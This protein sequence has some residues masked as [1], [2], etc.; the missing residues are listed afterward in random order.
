MLYLH[1]NGEHLMMC[2]PQLQEVRTKLQIN[3]LAVEYPQYERN[4]LPGEKQPVVTV[5]QVLE[6]CWSVVEYI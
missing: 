1:G 5:E 4:Y 2:R 6:D 3:I